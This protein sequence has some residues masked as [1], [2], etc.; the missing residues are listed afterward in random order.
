MKVAT[1]GVLLLMAF[2]AQISSQS[3]NRQV[4]SPVSVNECFGKGGVGILSASLY[5]DL[6]SERNQLILAEGRKWNGQNAALSETVIVFN[7]KAWQNA[8]PDGF[9]LSR[10]TI[11]SFEKDRVR[12]FDFNRMEGGFYRRHADQRQNSPI[13][14]RK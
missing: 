3:A 2:A 8:T 12:F 14:T 11:V 10:A 4:P 5:V 1:C 9:D 13:S 6:R 7:G